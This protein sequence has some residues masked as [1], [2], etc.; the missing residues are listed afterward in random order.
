M[1]HRFPSSIVALLLPLV[2][3]CGSSLGSSPDDPPKTLYVDASVGSDLAD[4]LPPL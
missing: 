2:A 3:G 4:A 1:R